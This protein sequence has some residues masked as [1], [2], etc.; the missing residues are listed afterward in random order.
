M[1]AIRVTPF[2]VVL[3][4]I[5]VDSE[6]AEQIARLCKSAPPEV[7]TRLQAAAIEKAR[8]VQEERKRVEEAGGSG[9]VT[10][11]EGWGQ[12]YVGNAVLPV[13]TPGKS[14]SRSPGRAKG[15]AKSPRRQLS[16]ELPRLRSY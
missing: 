10:P 11:D 8:K 14:P 3:V 6:I 4:Q 15:G 9:E 5:G 16:P 7:A 12:Q 2:D 13:G 1:L